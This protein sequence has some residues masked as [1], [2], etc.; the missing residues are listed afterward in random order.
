[1]VQQRLLAVDIQRRTE[2]L[3]ERRHGDFVT[4]KDTVSVGEVVHGL[5]RLTLVVGNLYD[6]D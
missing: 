5:V 1:M 2:F 6:T 4:M 3:G